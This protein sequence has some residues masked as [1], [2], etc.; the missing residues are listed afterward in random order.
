[1]FLSQEESLRKAAAILWHLYSNCCNGF[2]RIKHMINTHRNLV[3]AN[4]SLQFLVYFA[5]DE[6]GAYMCL[7]PSFC[8][9]KHGVHFQCPFWNSENTF[10]TH[11]PW[12]SAITRSASISVLVMYP[13]RLVILH[14]A[15]IRNRT[16]PFSLMKE[17]LFNGNSFA[18]DAYAKDILIASLPQQSHI[19]FVH[20]TGIC[21]DI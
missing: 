7:N 3:K 14:Y 11:N 8:K 18:P 16:Y 6:A 15:C 9:V 20:Q 19:T 4:K 13:F 1:M 21:Y 12:Y 2:C 17:S 5:D 10:H